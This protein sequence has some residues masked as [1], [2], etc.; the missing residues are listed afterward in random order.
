MFI[1]AC[2]LVFWQNIGKRMSFAQFIGNLEGLN[3]GHDFPKDLLKVNHYLSSV[4][5]A[6]GIFINRA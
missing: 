4:A 3:G 5:C 6:L 2:C 1:Y